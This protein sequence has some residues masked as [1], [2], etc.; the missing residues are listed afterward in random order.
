MK[1]IKILVF[2][3]SLA[4][5]CGHTSFAQSND[6][7]GH[8]KF[9]EI[10]SVNF[11]TSD[12]S[13]NNNTGIIGSKSR[14]VSGKFGDAMMFDESTTTNKVQYMGTG[15]LFFSPQ[16][17]LS[18]W[19]K[20][21]LPFA[22]KLPN[23][24]INTIM[25]T[26]TQ[27]LGIQRDGVYLYKTKIAQFD[28]AANPGWH[29]IVIMYDGTNLSAIVDGNQRGSIATSSPL[30][31][32]SRRYVG[33]NSPSANNHKFRG[34]I[35]D[36]RLYS[37]VL[38]DEEILKLGSLPQTNLLVSNTLATDR[39]SYQPGATIKMSA[40]F[41]IDPAWIAYLTSQGE[42][43]GEL[44][45]NIQDADSTILVSKSYA[46]P[47]ATGTTKFTYDFVL[48]T[49]TTFTGKT[50]S[51]ESLVYPTSK[52]VSES[53]KISGIQIADVATENPITL[54]D[55]NI[56]KTGQG[57]VSVRLDKALQ[58]LSAYGDSI[59]VGALSTTYA[60]RYVNLIASAFDTNFT[61]LGFSGSVLEEPGQLDRMYAQNINDASISTLLTGYNN[62]R[63]YGTDANRL[64]TYEKALPAALVYLSTPNTEKI[65]GT[66]M[67]TSGNWNAT[68]TYG[69]SGRSIFTKSS[70]S[71]ATTTVKGSV[72][73]IV[74][75]RTDPRNTGSVTISVDEQ[76][77]GTY[78]CAGV[79]PSSAAKINY[80]PFL[81]RV[82]NLTN[83]P[84][85]VKVVS[86]N[87]GY[88]QIDWIV[89]NTSLTAFPRVYV[90]GALLMTPT[91]Y[92]KNSPKGSIEANTMYN[93]VIKKTRETLASDGLNV[94]IAPTESTFNP[95]LHMSTDNV[96]PNDAGHKMIANTFINAATKNPQKFKA[97]TTVHVV[98]I[99]QNASSSV[100]MTG[101]DSR[102]GNIC[103]VKMTKNKSVKVG[104]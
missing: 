86:N 88:C 3:C 45:F 32:N 75:T 77:I 35:D 36:F 91:Q 12:D 54:Y 69:I 56:T 61:N 78:S 95:V 8:W 41:S 37:R 74:G 22:T 71:I 23:G 18:T 60:N 76:T 33:V 7:V 85:T 87:N 89:G 25:S 70:G 39:V 94:F 55:L 100:S 73:Y 40:S 31:K 24:G 50:L 43:Q 30:T 59:T 64:D 21:T 29:H 13:G 62:H 17:S 53:K 47:L 16:W 90:G 10:D 52:I 44:V 81:V 46:F 57:T 58:N 28:F 27:L 96:H 93:N 101:C 49:S 98:A 15:N 92:T 72:V 42:T 83:G 99:P 63:Y 65:F 11:T 34:L 26:D 51:L 1:Y 19:V 67:S 82:P 48:P 84:H 5:G 6:L 97:N 104:F 20:P 79:K 103:K 9:D 102:T 4:L 2:V 80:A 68:T 38:T 66:S 14:L